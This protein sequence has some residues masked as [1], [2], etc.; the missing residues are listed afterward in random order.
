MAWNGGVKKGDMR[1]W[2]LATSGL[3]TGRKFLF[4]VLSCPVL[5]H[6]VVSYLPTYL[7][8]QILHVTVFGKAKR[9]EARGVRI[10]MGIAIEIRGSRTEQNRTGHDRTRQDRT[11]HVGGRQHMARYLFFLYLYSSYI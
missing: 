1:L 10:A 8:T 5:I 4:L 9:D 6:H 3:R 11:G 7:P 2:R